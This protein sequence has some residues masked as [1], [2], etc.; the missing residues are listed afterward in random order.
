MYSENYGESDGAYTEDNEYVYEAELKK[1]PADKSVRDYFS[2]LTV[3][4]I[5]ALVTGGLK[6]ITANE[7]GIQYHFFINLEEFFGP[8]PVVCFVNKASTILEFLSS[9]RPLDWVTII[10]KHI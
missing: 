2:E 9:K 5:I 8:I 6:T 10:S 4:D 3:A 1:H 7:D